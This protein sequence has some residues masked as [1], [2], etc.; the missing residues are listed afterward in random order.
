M[1]PG[2]KILGFSFLLLFCYCVFFLFFVF[3]TSPDTNM[4][5]L[6]RVALVGGVG[7]GGIV[8][9]VIMYRL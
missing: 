5:R 1:P 8:E 2:A 6:P 4:S 9:I 7:W 3:K